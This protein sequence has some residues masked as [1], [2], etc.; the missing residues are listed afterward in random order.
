MFFA[1][2]SPRESEIDDIIGKC[3]IAIAADAADPAP[4]SAQG[5]SCNA[6]LRIAVKCFFP[7]LIRL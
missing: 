6:L 5:M 3:G 7:A 1:T 4:R 2:K